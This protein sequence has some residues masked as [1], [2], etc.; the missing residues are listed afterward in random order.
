MLLLKNHLQ[1]LSYTLHNIS[2]Y[3]HLPNVYNIHFLKQ[4]LNPGIESTMTEDLVGAKPKRKINKKH[5][6]LVKP[7]KTGGSWI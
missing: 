1:V 4:R 7:A 3:I 2:A 5:I 6:L